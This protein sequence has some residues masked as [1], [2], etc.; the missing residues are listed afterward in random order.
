MR[1]ALRT[2]TLPLALTMG[3]Q[4]G[5]CPFC[6]CQECGT[7][8]PHPD[9][10]AWAV[11]CPQCGMIGPPAPDPLRAVADWNR[12][13]PPPPGDGTRALRTG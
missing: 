6:A 4:I 10:P 13:T 12:R 11:T 8:Q 9:D 7:E 1:R 2:S 3:G 5:P